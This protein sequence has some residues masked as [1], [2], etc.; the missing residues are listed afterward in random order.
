MKNYAFELTQYNAENE[1]EERT[2]LKVR[3]Q[4]EKEIDF[5]MNMAT[6]PSKLKKVLSKVG[7]VG[8]LKFFFDGPRICNEDT[9]KSSEWQDEMIKAFSQNVEYKTPLDQS[10][11]IN[12]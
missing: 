10:F 4:E 7:K 1:V 5:R 11:C 6:S 3:D 9:S 8:T 2:Q 12:R